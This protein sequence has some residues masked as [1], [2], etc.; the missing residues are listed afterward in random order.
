[1]DGAHVGTDSIRSRLPAP[2][3]RPRPGALRRLTTV[4]FGP[5]RRDP[6][7][8]VFPLAV[9]MAIGIGLLGHFLDADHGPSSAP[10]VGAAAQIVDLQPHVGHPGATIERSDLGETTDRSSRTR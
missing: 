10:D 7:L 3:A 8:V 1:M 9:V 6:R 2:E 4:T 5:L